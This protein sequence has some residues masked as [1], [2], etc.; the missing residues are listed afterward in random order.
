MVKK[1]DPQAET[2]TATDEPRGWPD[3]TAEEKLA[4]IYA[5]LGIEPDG[6]PILAISTIGGA[7]GTPLTGSLT[8]LADVVANKANG[9]AARTAEEAIDSAINII[10][11]VGDLVGERWRQ[12][13][14]YQPDHDDALSPDGWRSL[15][16]KRTDLLVGAMEGG[17]WYDVR[18]YSRE[19]AALAIA[20]RESASRHQDAGRTFPTG[21]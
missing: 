1:R 6:D 9:Q 20:A 5:K 16:D 3:L 12:N 18:R 15:L 11:R 2:A 7:L 13:E 14:K 21:E 8:R 10:D 19:L 4:R 17:K